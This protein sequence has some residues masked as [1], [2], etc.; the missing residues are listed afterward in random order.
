MKI[1]LEKNSCNTPKIRDKDK[2]D[3]SR[4]NFQQLSPSTE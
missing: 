1:S 2:S 3:T 4:V